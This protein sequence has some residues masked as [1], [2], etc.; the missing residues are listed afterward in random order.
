MIKLPLPRVRSYRTISPLLIIIDGG[1][2]SVA[3]SVSLRPPCLCLHTMQAS[4]GINP[5]RSPD[6]PHYTHVTR[7]PCLPY[8][9]QSK[10][11]IT[12]LLHNVKRVFLIKKLGGIGIKNEMSY[13]INTQEHAGYKDC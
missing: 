7:L 3:L 4:Q 8:S 2:I 9:Q 5:V 11:I 13:C 12:L 10:V 6:F 1:I